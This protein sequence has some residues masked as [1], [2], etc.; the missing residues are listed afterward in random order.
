M[1]RNQLSGV[2]VNA[3]IL[4]FPQI[5]HWIDLVL[6][7]VNASGENRINGKVYYLVPERG[8]CIG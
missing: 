8:N 4:R 5:A 3:E 6:K 7:G 1:G 2:V